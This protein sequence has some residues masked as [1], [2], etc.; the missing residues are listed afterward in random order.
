MVRGLA[1]WSFHRG[2]FLPVLLFPGGMR[3]FATAFAVAFRLPS[4]PSALRIGTGCPDDRLPAPLAAF[5]PPG[6]AVRESGFPRLPF[7]SFRAV[8]FDRSFSPVLQP[9]RGPPL[10]PPVDPR[11]SF[12]VRRWPF[13]LSLP[14]GDAPSPLRSSPGTTPWPSRQRAGIFCPGP[15]ASRGRIAGGDRH[16]RGLLRTSVGCLHALP[17]PRCSF[18]PTVC[19]MCAA[20]SLAPP[21]LG[22]VEV[23]RT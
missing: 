4:C 1:G 21:A 16:P 15:V 13:D 14:P 5:V 11:G 9:A 17:S 20:S 7:Q 8:R 23:S 12:Q 22:Q 10:P 3:S 19:R 18:R 2:R 6:R